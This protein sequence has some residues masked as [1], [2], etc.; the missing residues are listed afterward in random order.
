MICSHPE[1]TGNHD[2]RKR[3]NLCPR[4]RADELARSRRYSTT[5]AGILAHV[6]H[7]AYRRR[8]REAVITNR[9]GES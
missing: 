3:T 4:T 2:L 5:A 7:D 9:T 8:Q 1:C 6:R